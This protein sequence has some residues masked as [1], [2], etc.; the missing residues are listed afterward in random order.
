MVDT[1]SFPIFGQFRLGF[2]LHDVAR[3]RRKVV[4]KA[5]KPKGITRSQWWLL[6][7]LS[8]SDGNGMV[9]TE[10]ADVLD[11]GKVALGGLLDR[12]ESN[13]YIR[14]VADPT[15]RR[16]KRVEITPSGR[17]IFESIRTLAS[18]LNQDMAQ[19]VTR[20]E[21]ALVEDVLERMKQRLII[22]DQRGRKTSSSAPRLE[23]EQ[24][25]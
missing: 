3:L 2:L 21:I 9:Q 10:L 1:S 5:L 18:Q 23:A 20:E 15:D 12:L 4:D 8:S 22:M 16:A 6:A 14:R 7:K 25:E 11:I 17:E 24:A 19:G 13:G